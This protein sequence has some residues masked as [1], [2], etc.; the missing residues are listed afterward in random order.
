MTAIDITISNG[1]PIFGSTSERSLVSAWLGPHPGTFVEVGAGWAVRGSQTYALE[2]VGWTGLLIEPS[3][4]LANDLR[5]SR[6]SEVVEAA[7]IATSTIEQARLWLR[8]G[9]WQCIPKESRASVEH[10]FVKTFTLDNIL[11]S[12]GLNRVDFLSVDV[13]G[14]ES[15]VLIGFSAEKYRPRLILVDDRNCLGRVRRILRRS[16]YHLFIRTGT[17]AW[18]IPSELY[19]T[20]HLQQRLLLEWHYGPA[21]IY[22]RVKRYFG[23]DTTE[24]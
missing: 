20:T 4:V 17:N 13:C 8:Y 21:R 15:D 18:F 22:R 10:I 23:R 1:R 14:S 19:P 9:D 6:K 2:L 24:T 3:P 5:K 12:R 11:Q 7:C 16:G